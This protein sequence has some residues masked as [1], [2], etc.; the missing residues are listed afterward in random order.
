MTRILRLAAAVWLFSGG[1]V[2]EAPGGGESSAAHKGGEFSA[3]ASVNTPQGTRSLAF[4]LV[5]SNPMTIE[6]TQPFK[7]VLARGGQQMLLKVIR[8]TAQG[9][10]RLGT[11]EFP[12]DLV[13]AEPDGDDIRY[14]VISSR[15]IQYEE[16]LYGEESLDFPFSLLVV[17]VPEIGTGDGTI[18]TKAALYID[19]EG[20]VRAEQYRGDPGSL[21]DVK[22]L[23]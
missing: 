16:N 22:R 1:L 5:V 21:K 8:G 14:Y 13:V 23:K 6:Q 19:E 7:E 18:F 2:A 20:H 4:N 9:K 11:L 3:T 10:V 17:N 12:V 15:Q